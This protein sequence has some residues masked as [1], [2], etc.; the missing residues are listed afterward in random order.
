LPQPRFK[1]FA[2]GRAYAIEVEAGEFEQ[3]FSP[4]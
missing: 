3:G 4:W 1:P 2:G